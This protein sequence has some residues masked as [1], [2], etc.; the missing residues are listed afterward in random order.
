MAE[1]TEKKQKVP[2][3]KYVREALESLKNPKG[4][5]IAAIEKYLKSAHSEIEFKHNLIR[6]TVKVC[7]GSCLVC[8]GCSA[9][10]C[11]WLQ[12]EQN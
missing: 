8:W 5:S 9:S 6:L 2:Y 1:K 10:R 12:V 11:W 4:V 3:A 7:D